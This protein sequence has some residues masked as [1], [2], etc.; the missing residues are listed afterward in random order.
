[1]FRQRVWLVAAQ[2][3]IAVGCSNGSGETSGS[4]AFDAGGLPGVGGS[5]DGGSANSSGG[6]SGSGG[7]LGG[8]SSSGASSGGGSSSGGGGGSSGGAGSG[9]G[10]GGPSSSGS[11]GGPG[12]SGGATLGD[13]GAPGLSRCGAPLDT[14]APTAASIVQNGPLATT[15]YSTGLP[16]STTYKSLTVFY[17]TNANGPFLVVMISPGLTE[18]L[19]YLT[20]W[21]QRFASYGYVAVFVEAND[22]N[23]D[24]EAVRA[25]GLWAAIGSIK[26]ENTRA[27]SPLEGKLSDCIVTSGHSLGGGASFTIAN[28]H[29]NDVK[30]ALGFNPY[31]PVTD[32]TA[33]VVPTLAI[34]GQ[35]DTTAPPAQHGRRQ[36]DSMSATIEKEYVEITGGNHQAAL[37]PS[38]IPGQ[39]AVAWIKTTVDGDARY[40][41]FLAEAATGLSDFAT[42]LP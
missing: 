31:D 12:S 17:P 10:S 42:T 9:S 16:T 4:G 33:I 5:E 25:D 23:T 28:S 11:G 32:F 1:M 20:L 3:L 38:T 13:G 40:R 14:A 2:A 22:T 6:A 34:T 21:A 18:V 29:P 41:P 27:G 8:G 7:S 19:A 36:Y 30:G 24:S 37:F 15:S 35:D 39:Y 26:G